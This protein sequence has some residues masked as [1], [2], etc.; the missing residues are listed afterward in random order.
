MWLTVETTG[1][2]GVSVKFEVTEGRESTLPPNIGAC[3]GLHIADEPR[4][5]HPTLGLSPLTQGHCE[6]SCR[7]QSPYPA[8]VPPAWSAIRGLVSQRQKQG[9][10]GSA[11]GPLPST[12]YLFS[13]FI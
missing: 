8:L 7:R 10:W 3:Q 11:R 2:P 5:Q 13:I 6:A 4:R 1:A 9:W 12:A